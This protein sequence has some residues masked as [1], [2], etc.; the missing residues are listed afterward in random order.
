[1]KARK[2]CGLKIGRDGFARTGLIPFVAATGRSQPSGREFVF[3]L[4]AWMRFLIVAP[5]GYGVA[6]LDWWGQEIAIAAV[7][8]GDENLLGV[9][10]TGDAHLAAGKLFG[11]IPPDGTDVTHAAERNMVKPI[12][13]GT[14]YGA[15]VNSWAMRV[16]IETRAT[17]LMDWP[18]QAIGDEMMR[19]AA[20]EATAA[21]IDLFCTVHD[22][23]ILIAPLTEIGAKVERMRE[24]MNAASAR[25]LGGFECDVHTDIFEHPKRF[26]EKKGA[27]MEAVVEACLDELEGIEPPPLRPKRAPRA[28]R[29]GDGE[30]LH[31]Y[32]A[33]IISNA[34]ARIRTDDD[35]ARALR[36]LQRG[37]EEGERQLHSGHRCGA[38][39]HAA[40]SHW[41]RRDARG[42]GE[43]HPF[44]TPEH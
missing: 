41:R 18:M 40:S 1:M 16:P 12:M 25:V 44:G 29:L 17:T 24:I 23:F 13:F 2:K 22:A 19:I 32:V 31:P 9:Y 3:A 37:G 15:G 21:G 36:R 42:G 6:S 7:L 14:N 26:F 33:K 28:M 11:I 10:E 30:T 39:P 5:P 27:K 38:R 34:E 4:P 8:S 43:D 20:C 35:P